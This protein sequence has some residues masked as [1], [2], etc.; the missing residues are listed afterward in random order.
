MPY[1]NLAAELSLE[2]LMRLIESPSETASLDFK[3]TLD[4][5]QSRDR[6]EFAKDVLAMANSGGGHVVVGIEDKTRRRVGIGLES[7]G[8]LQEAKSVNDKLKKYCGGYV[9]VLV[10]QHEIEDPAQGRVRLCLIYIPPAIARVPAQDDGVCPD[11]TDMKKQKWVF[12]RGD[13]YVRKGDESVKVET[14]ADLAQ[15]PVGPEI[16]I[17]AANE[18]VR[19]YSERLANSLRSKLPPLLPNETPDEMCGSQ[20]IAALLPPKDFFV[21]AA[22]GAGKSLHLRHL[23]LEALKHKELPLL[24]GAGRYKGQDFLR[25]LDQAIAPFSK[26]PAD[27]LFKAASICGLH[28]LLVIDGINECEPYLENLVKDVQALRLRG[29]F[30]LLAASQTDDLPKDAFDCNRI[31]V[32][33]LTPS[34]K[35]FIYCYH[36]N[37]PP[38]AAIDYLC[39]G[40]SNGYDLAI[41]G[42]CHSVMN[43]DVTRVELYERYCR[44]SLLNGETVLA[45]LLREIAGRMGQELTN[46]CPRDEFERFSEEFLLSQGASLEL[47]DHL[48]SSRL[49][50]LT[51]TNFE[52]EHELLF[53]YFRAEWTRRR[54][55]TVGALAPELAKPKN[56]SL[57]PFILPRYK[58]VSSVHALLRTLARP[59]ALR[60]VLLGRC[61]DTAREALLADC[62]ELFTAAASDVTTVTL[63]FNEEKPEPAKLSLL[64]LTLLGRHQWT[65]YEVLFSDAIATSLD[66]HELQQVS[67]C[68]T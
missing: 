66:D 19:T 50:S 16:T 46:F 44:K 39:Q 56:E 48:K 63:N 20:L 11:P 45:A 42:R 7:S 25:L 24:I 35:R 21:L 17:D 27:T 65:P 31:S 67:I 23:C 43:G 30:R 3:E 64:S 60:E 1:E 26:E 38:T 28:L 32:S 59:E 8:S 41:A 53:D 58:E 9:K 54:Y 10:A 18:I 33:P 2:C 52:F 68:L 34:H 36:A 37:M 55:L 57:L 22:S 13:V 15:I 62:R 12:R 6:V 40:F 5:N 14:P 51:D 47:L 49:V 61:G 29:S 4:V